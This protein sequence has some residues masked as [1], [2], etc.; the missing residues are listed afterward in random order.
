MSQAVHDI[1]WLFGGSAAERTIRLNSPTL[2]LESGEFH[3]MDPIELPYVAAGQWM[4]SWNVRVPSH[5]IHIIPHYNSAYTIYAYIIIYLIYLIYLLYLISLIY[6][7]YLIYLIHPQAHDVPWNI[8]K[9]FFWRVRPNFPSLPGQDPSREI[10]E[11]PEI[12]SVLAGW[13]D[14]L[15][16]FT[17]FGT[18]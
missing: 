8:I 2:L 10:R 7:I 18:R 14:R 16:V 9:Y 4:D 3:P 11:R 6:L 13:A 17:T 15:D 5:S 12:T 1:S